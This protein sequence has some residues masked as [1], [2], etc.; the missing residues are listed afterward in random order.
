MASEKKQVEI[1][2]D[3]L[4]NG[5]PLL[6]VPPRFDNVLVLHSY[7][8]DVDDS[9]GSNNDAIFAK[10]MHHID[11]RLTRAGVQR[12][13]H[14]RTPHSHHS[15]C[16]FLHKH[17]SQH[18]KLCI[19]VPPRSEVDAHDTIGNALRDMEATSIAFGIPAEPGHL[20]LVAK[21]GATH[22]VVLPGCA[23]L[24][25]HTNGIDSIIKHIVYHASPPTKIIPNLAIGGFYT[26]N[27]S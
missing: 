17:L 27:I 5:K 4:K 25:S 19:I 6:K 12:I 21:L 20:S 2:C 23:R 11:T 14:Q 15:I 26:R 7:T 13:E 16:A 1:V 10:T 18:V 22:I 3:W 9:N 24:N 8:K